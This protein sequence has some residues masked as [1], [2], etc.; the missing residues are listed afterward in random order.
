LNNQ[1]GIDPAEAAERWLNDGHSVTLVTVMTTWGSAPRLPGSQ[2]AVRD[3]GAFAGSVSAGCIEGAVIEAALA[4]PTCRRLAYGIADETAW[5]AGLPCGGRI[6]LLLEP[7]AG[8]AARQALATW[9]A[10]RR[11]G[12]IAVRAVEPTSGACRIIDPDAESDALAACARD[13]A[14]RDRSGE[15]FCDGQTWFLT[16]ANPPID[17][18]IV[19]A[20]HIAQ[21]LVRM[22]SPLGYRIRII[23]PRPAFATAERFPGIALL[24]EYPDD[25][26]AQAPLHAHSAVVV[27]AHDPKIDDPALIAALHSPAF[28][29][30]ALGSQKTQ[31][32]RRERLKAASFSDDD[33]ARLHGPVGLPIG[34]KTPEEIAVSIIADI[35]KTQHRA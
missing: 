26:L 9:N 33:L 24:C 14:L 22:A 19:G 5:S 8:D 23:D 28:Y 20:V 12:R 4:A 15:I 2:M 7:L 35:I 16:V 17:L 25:V 34:S 10:L 6:E 3:D 27:L 1:A 31:A 30:G 32:A 13:A 29:I 18:V 21:A 11:R